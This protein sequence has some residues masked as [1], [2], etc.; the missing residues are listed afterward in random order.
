MLIE[1]DNLNTLMHAQQPDEFEVGL[2]N[3]ISEVIYGERKYSNFEK[4]E[5][6]HDDL[7]VLSNK[8]FQKYYYFFPP[9]LR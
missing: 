4:G 2:I 5:I 1:F 3:R 9:G 6:G 8:M 7:I